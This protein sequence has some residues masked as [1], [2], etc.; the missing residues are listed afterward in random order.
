MY[1]NY[2]TEMLRVIKEMD[3]YIYTDEL[4]VHEVSSFFFLTETQN[5]ISLLS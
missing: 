4:F 1:A 3:Q 2:Y 5:S